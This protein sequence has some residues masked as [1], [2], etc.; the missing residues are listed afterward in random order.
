MK[1]NRSQRIVRKAMGS[2]RWFP[3]GPAKLKAMIND[4]VDQAEVGPVTGR[5]VAAISPHA[6]YE[7]SGRVAGYVFRVLRDQAKQ[8]DGPETVVILGLNHQSGFPGVALMDGDAIV[9][10]L[11]ETALDQA[12]AALMTKNSAR[13][14]MDYRPH[15][16]E[17]SAENQVPFV[18]AVLPDARLVIGM[19]G[20]H[21]PQTIKD[22]TVALDRLAQKKKITVVASSDMLH[23]PDYKRVT[24]TDQQSLKTL[25]AMQSRKIL[26]DW[27]YRHQTFCGVAA[28]VV[29]MDFAKTQ[30]CTEG[31]VL[32]YRN[33]GDYFPESR[34]QWVVGYGAV[35]F[36]V[37][38]K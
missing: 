29:A 30:G 6:G 20:D 9:T 26:E 10:P 18:Q 27:S 1:N 25:I 38:G 12:A 7:Y 5:V 35:V 32:Y 11:G 22:L 19:I 33:S 37:P 17:H 15:Y 23:D 14:R 16:G 28:V 2:G 3:S 4:F 34:G 24:Q 13:I 36:A 31:L 21:D 8:G